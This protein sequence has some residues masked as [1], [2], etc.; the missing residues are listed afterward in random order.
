[1]S[2]ER[3]LHCQ[4]DPLLGKVPVRGEEEGTNSYISGNNS[5]KGNKLHPGLCSDLVQLHRLQCSHTRPPNTSAVVLYPMVCKGL[6]SERVIM[7]LPSA[8][9][10]QKWAEG[11]GV[12]LSLG[13]FFA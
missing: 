12:G 8:Q 10:F 3:F 7:F 1:M 6:C 13:W 4:G 2:K 5:S 11:F 9:A